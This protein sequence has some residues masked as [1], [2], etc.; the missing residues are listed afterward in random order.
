MSDSINH[1]KHYTSHPSGVAQWEI[2]CY[3]SAVAEIVKSIWPRTYELFEEYDLHGAHLS[4]AQVRA[5]RAGVDPVVV[6]GMK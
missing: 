5:L 6:L 4:R 2:R 3:A 1:P